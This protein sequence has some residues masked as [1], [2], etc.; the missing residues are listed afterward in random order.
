MTQNE[1][2]IPGIHSRP[3]STE[4]NAYSDFFGVEWDYGGK[5]TAHID[6]L[7]IDQWPVKIV[8][9]SFWQDT[10]D[11]KKLA[12]KVQ[13]VVLRALYG[14]KTV[15]SKLDEYYK[16]AKD[17]GLA[18]MLYHYL[19][20]DLDW[21]KHAD[22]FIAIE[23][24]YPSSF[25]WAD[26]EENGGLGKTA[27]ESWIKKY[28]DKVL[29]YKPVGFYS[30]KG[31]LDSNLGKTNWL[32]NLPL[33]IAAWTTA[34][35]PAMPLEYIDITNPKT[36]KLWQWSS[37]GDGKTYG[38]SSAYIDL[39]RYNG[40][41]EQFNAEYKTNIKDLNPPIPP[42][43][44]VEEFPKRVSTTTGLKIRT[45][46]TSINDNNLIGIVK[47]GTQ[48]DAVGLSEIDPNFYKIIAYANKTYFKDV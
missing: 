15:D 48:F 14:N 25:M 29:Q 10:I 12:T 37:K 45:S 35:Q 27:L 44:P 38:V 3:F 2:F 21:S 6:K 41:I 18:I 23:K 33:W 24:N 46:P 1:I 13:V 4:L 11:F 17:N 42:P 47:T 40:T 8:D 20:P 34:S 16:G 31:F 39:D 32:K 26:L 43:P 30:S 9:L 5:L 7:T 19:K 22:A 36:W 28:S